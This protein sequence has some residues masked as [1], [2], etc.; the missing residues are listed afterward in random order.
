MRDKLND[1][2][3][4]GEDHA[5]VYIVVRPKAVRGDQVPQINIL[6]SCVC[7]YMHTCV[8]V[9]IHTWHP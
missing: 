3:D 5:Q 8:C 4:A 7:V 1:S 2:D 9:H 6:S